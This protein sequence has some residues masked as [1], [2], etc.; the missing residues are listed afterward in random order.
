MTVVSLASRRAAFS[1]RRL[2]LPPAIVAVDAELA[3]CEE[4][5]SNAHHRLH[6]GLLAL[7]DYECLLTEWRGLC[8]KRARLAG[9]RAVVE[10]SGV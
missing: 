6:R 8:A 2:R 7:H 4:Q 1:A 9:E 5:L 10:V 3:A